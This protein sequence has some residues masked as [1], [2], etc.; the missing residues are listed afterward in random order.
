MS[1]RLFDTISNFRTVPVA[2]N[3]AG[4]SLQSSTIIRCFINRLGLNVALTHKNRVISRQR[5]QGNCRG[6]EKEAYND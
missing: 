2:T 6:I 5:K 1:I 3:R 4:K